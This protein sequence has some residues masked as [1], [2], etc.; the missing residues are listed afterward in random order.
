[1]A[2]RIRKRIASTLIRLAKKIGFRCTVLTHKKSSMHRHGQ[3]Y[4]I[5]TLM[6]K[7]HLAKCSIESSPFL[8]KGHLA[9]RTL[10]FFRVRSRRVLA[11]PPIE[12]CPHEY[13]P[14]CRLHEL[15]D[16]FE[17]KHCAIDSNAKGAIEAKAAESPS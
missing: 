6:Q 11:W 15:A 7:L 17:A 13:G 8:Q 14:R 9:R 2:A 3:W 1:M 10:G 12:E 4:L 16:F 5:E